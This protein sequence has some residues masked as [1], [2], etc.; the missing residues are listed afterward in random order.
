[1]VKLRTSYSSVFPVQPTALFDQRPTCEEMRT[2]PHDGMT[3][4]R[5]VSWVT[6]FRSKS[7]EE[8]L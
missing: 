7:W 1:M 4:F 5:S 2:S 8:A 6:V 3:V